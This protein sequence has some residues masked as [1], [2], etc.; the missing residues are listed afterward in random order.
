MPDIVPGRFPAKRICFGIQTIPYQKYKTSQLRTEKREFEGQWPGIG[1]TGQESEPTK[2]RKKGIRGEN[3][4]T[5][6]FIRQNKPKQ[7][8]E[9]L[10]V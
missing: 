3:S 6:K 10:P 2:N 1:A 7:E 5:L 4:G 8:T 9:A